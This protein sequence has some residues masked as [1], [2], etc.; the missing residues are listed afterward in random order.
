MFFC[1]LKFEKH[2]DYQDNSPYK[3]IMFFGNPWF[4]HSDRSLI[5]SVNKENSNETSSRVTS[6]A[7]S[8]HHDYVAVA[9][10][11]GRI[12]IYFNSNASISTGLSACNG[13]SY[14]SQI[15]WMGK[16][17]N[18]LVAGR[19]DGLLIYLDVVPS[20]M[21]DSKRSDE[22]ILIDQNYEMHSQEISQ[23]LWN[24]KQNDSI[25]LISVD[26]SGTCTLW[27]A[28]LVPVMRYDNGSLV[29]TI[30]FLDSMFSLVRIIL[31]ITS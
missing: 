8:H 7:V 13:E 24:E 26:K 10:Y 22:I 3:T 4:Y 6:V 12:T 25:Y 9:S 17:C 23:L 5:H 11:D 20:S 21:L 28:P 14:Y 18:Y 1:S 2:F 31:S 27:K 29:N 15:C 16:S 19:A 30:V